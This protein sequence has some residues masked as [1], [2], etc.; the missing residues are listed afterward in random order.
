MPRQGVASAFKYGRAVGTIEAVVAC[1]QISLRVIEPSVWKRAFH[2]SPDKEA[3]RQLAAQIFPFAHDLL[4][5]KCHHQRT[6]AIL[7]ALYTATIWDKAAVALFD[8]SAVE[9]T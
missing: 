9:P 8:K 7:L 1:C 4:N 2:L 5:L 6:E 3:S